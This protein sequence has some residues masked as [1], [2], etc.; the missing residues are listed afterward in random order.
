MTKSLRSPTAVAPL[1]QQARR[2]RVERPDPEA[3]AT[4]ERAAELPDALAQLA[5]R[6][7][8]EG[9]REDAARIGARRDQPRQPVG[10]DPRLARAG[11]G[12]DQQRAAGCVTASSCGGFSSRASASRENRL[13]AGGSPPSAPRAGAAAVRVSAP[14]SIGATLSECA[15]NIRASKARACRAS[16]PGQTRP[17]AE[18]TAA[19][20]VATREAAEQDR[21]AHHARAHAPL[22]VGGHGVSSGRLRR[23]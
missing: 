13:V 20:P 22:P 17:P 5:G 14:A 4:P 12:D 8:G 19:T 21:L 11:A 23:A 2:D 18:R 15:R 10:D 6:L 3:A 1:A 7:V 9:D 16:A